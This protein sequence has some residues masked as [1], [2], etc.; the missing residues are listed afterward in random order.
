VKP[1]D[2]D[3]L[4]ALAQFVDDDGLVRNLAGDAIGAEKI[5]YV[6]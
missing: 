3:L 5:D 1:S 2:D 6:E 4:A